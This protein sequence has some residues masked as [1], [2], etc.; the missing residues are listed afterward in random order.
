MR[1]EFSNAYDAIIVGSGPGGGSVASKLSKLG[2]KL[3]IL[4]QGRGDQLKGTTAQLLPMALV[5]GKSLH[6]TQQ[7]LGLIHAVA[8]GG[9]SVIYYANAFDP[10]YE[11]FDAYGIDLRPFVAE[12][13]TDLPIAPLTDELVGPAAMRIMESA[14]DLGFQWNKM[15]KIVY[16]DKCR[17]NCDKCVMGC[18]FAAKWTSRMYMEDVCANGARLITEARVER[19]LHE[20]LTAKGV[21]YTHQGEKQRAY[22]DK[23]I[24]AAGGIGTPLILRRSGLKSAGSDFFF[25]PLIFAIGEVDDLNAGKEFPMAAGVNFEADGYLMTDLVLP[26]W[27]YW[28]FTAQ[29]L[30]FDRLPAHSRSLPIMIKVRDELGGQIT[31]RGRVR[32][33]LTSTEYERLDKGYQKAESILRNAGARNIY[34]TWYLAVHPGGTAKIGDVVDPN[35][36]TEVDNLFICD[37]SVIPESWGLPP[38]LTLLALGNRLGVHLAGHDNAV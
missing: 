17:P 32:K 19:V 1:S 4:E 12:V 14:R 9:S 35:L 24:L 7:M 3:L 31:K 25:D 37:C 23:I 21:E 2:W 18:P 38:S 11:M 33:R 10:P 30:R 22:A 16:Q 13:K 28:L 8:L 29:V 36:K 15:P 20:N 5:P 27:L 6:F 26:R 34:K